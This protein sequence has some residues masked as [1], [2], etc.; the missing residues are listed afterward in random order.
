MEAHVL[1]LMPHLPPNIQLW[2]IDSRPDLFR[3]SK[4][5]YQETERKR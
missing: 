2:S 5:K 1:L 3:A 4:E